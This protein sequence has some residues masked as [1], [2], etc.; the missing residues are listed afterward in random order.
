M[1]V[2]GVRT[3]VGRGFTIVGLILKSR[4]GGGVNLSLTGLDE[5]LMGEDRYMYRSCK[6]LGKFDKIK[7]EGNN[8]DNIFI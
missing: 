8:I 6:Y 5:C 1:F 7:S 2:W 3:G 4:E